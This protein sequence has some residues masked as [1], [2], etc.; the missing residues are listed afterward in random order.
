[1]ASEESE[2]TGNCPGAATSPLLPGAVWGLPAKPGRESVLVAKG[3]TTLT[4][5]W[6]HPCH[7]CHPCK[8]TSN[9]SPA[10]GGGPIMAT[11]QAL[12]LSGALPQGYS[13]FQLWGALLHS[14]LNRTL[15]STLQFRRFRLHV[16]LSK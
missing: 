6:Q 8:T 4:S 16:G 9:L 7:S 5:H 2:T 15:S 10:L 13:L 11:G 1:M 12:P 3:A 14:F